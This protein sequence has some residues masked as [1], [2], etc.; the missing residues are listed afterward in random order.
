MTFI[1]TVIGFIVFWTIVG[2]IFL[3]LLVT[4][5]EKANDKGSDIENGDM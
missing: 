1:Y 3:S 2:L 4:A 5:S